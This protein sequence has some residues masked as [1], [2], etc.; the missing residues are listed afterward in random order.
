MERASSALVA[1]SDLVLHHLA[2]SG[3]ALAVPDSKAT[4]PINSD[5]ECVQYAQTMHAF[6]IANANKSTNQSETF[7]QGTFADCAVQYQPGFIG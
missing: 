5:T 1:S 4:L 6:D 2:H 3:P 7:A